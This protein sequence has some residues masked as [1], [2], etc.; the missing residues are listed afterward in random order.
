MPK[1][2]LPSMKELSPLLA[3]YQTP[4]WKPAIWQMLNT[5]LPFIALLA[6][7]FFSLRY[8]YWLTLLLSIPTAGFLIRTFIL[9]HD[10]GHNSF[11]PSLQGQPHHR[12][13]PRRDGADPLRPVVEV[14]CHPPR[15][16]QQPG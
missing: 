3:P 16:Q 12:L 8:S 1:S 7:M 2:D 14:A 6:L 10:C 15:H 5:I 9:F 4:A 11:T 13:S